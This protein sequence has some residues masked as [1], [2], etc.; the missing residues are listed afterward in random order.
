VLATVVHVIVEQLAFSDSG[1]SCMQT[2]SISSTLHC[3]ESTVS[4]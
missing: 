1:C 4:R 2:R 3:H